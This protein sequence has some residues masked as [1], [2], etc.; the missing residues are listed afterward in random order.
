MYEVIYIIIP[1]QFYI[2]LYKTL[3]L[4]AKWSV[5]SLAASLLNSEEVIWLV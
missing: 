5:K 3:L 2:I 1:S 4:G